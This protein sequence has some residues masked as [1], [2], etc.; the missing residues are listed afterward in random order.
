MDEQRVVGELDRFAV[1]GFIVGKPGRRGNLQ[2]TDV[3]ERPLC[4]V[5][6]GSLIQHVRIGAADVMPV[7]FMILLQLRFLLRSERS[8]SFVA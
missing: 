5:K 1:E 7:R 6:V 2:H 3:V 4:R 8:T